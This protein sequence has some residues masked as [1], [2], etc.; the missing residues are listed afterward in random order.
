MNSIFEA[1][2]KQTKQVTLYETATYRINAFWPIICTYNCTEG[3]SKLSKRK[4]IFLISSLLIFTSFL[5]LFPLSNLSGNI[6]KSYSSLIG[7]ESDITIPEPLAMF[8][9]GSGLIG[10]GLYVRRRFP[11]K[12]S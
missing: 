12:V 8:L 10:F 11:K 4:I 5:F 2:I 9:F 7:H 3:E 6:H 1:A